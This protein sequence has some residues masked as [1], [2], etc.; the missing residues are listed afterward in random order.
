MTA[1]STVSAGFIPRIFITV[2]VHF[3]T[4]DLRHL[5]LQAHEAEPRRVPRLELDQH[6]QIALWPA[7]LPQRGAKEGLS[8]LRDSGDRGSPGRPPEC[9]AVS[10]CAPEPVLATQIYGATLMIAFGSAPNISAA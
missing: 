1:P 3:I 2:E 8:A 4:Q 10:G 5:A 7:V 9:E 6:V